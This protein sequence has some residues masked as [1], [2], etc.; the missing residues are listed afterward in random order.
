[1]KSKKAEISISLILYTFIGILVGIVLFQA[2]AQSVGQTVNTATL[3]NDSQT[4]AAN[5]ESIYLTDYRSLTDVVIL[6]ATDNTTIEAANY[7]VTN[8]VVY[9]GALSVEITTDETTY[10][11]S[12]VGISGTVQPV[13]YIADGGGRA[14][15]NLIPI[16][17][18]LAIVL[19]ALYPVYSSKILEVMG[20]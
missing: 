12:S 11:S 18:A 2:V 7:T 1:M 17:F 20:K 16:F 15:A 10:E 8:N 5:G 14:M 3:N 4:L 9:N 13:T 19:I 6:N